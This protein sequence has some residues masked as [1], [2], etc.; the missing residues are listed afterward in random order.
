MKII[1]GIQLKNTIKQIRKYQNNHK[2][3]DNLYRELDSLEINSLQSFSFQN[4]ND[5]FD[6][7]S[8]VL[9]VIN[10]IIVHPHIVTKSED[11]IIRAELAG[12]I[13]HD[14]FQKVMKD[15]SLWKEKDIDMVPENVYYHQ[16]IDELKIYENI[17]IGMLIKLLDQEINKYYDFYVSILPSIGSQYEIVL[18]N[19]SIETA[20]SKV[21]KLQRKLRHIK[22]SHFYKEISKCD[23]SLKKIQP[24]NILLKDRLYNYCFKFYRKFVAYEDLESL[25]SDFRTYYLFQMLKTLNKKGFVLD[26]SVQ[27]NTHNLSFIYKDYKVNLLLSR[28]RSGISLTIN[29]KDIV[30]K[31]YLYLNTDRVIKDDSIDYK[32]TEKFNTIDI[33]TIWNLYSQ[34][35]ITKPLFKSTLSEE[36]MVYEWLNSKFEEILVKKD[37]YKKYC[38][39]CRSKNLIEDGGYFECANCKTQYVFKNQSEVLDTIWFMRIRRS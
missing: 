17:F 35:D 39:V 11:I 26:E 4:D 18:E 21:D 28:Y 14:Q 8:F 25:K 33:L 7:V 5:F 16:Y 38:P 30:A 19:E 32:N 31:H 34:D 15:S 22:N 6:E 13:A 12:H 2:G 27:N 36:V 10:S 20:L 9:S 23:L 3:L 29:H 37:L 1:E 24:T